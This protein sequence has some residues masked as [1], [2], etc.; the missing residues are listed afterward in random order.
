VTDGGLVGLVET[1]Q[2]VTGGPANLSPLDISADLTVVVD[3]H[4]LAVEAYT[5]RVFVEFPSL[6][7]VVDVLRAAPD[8]PETPEGAGENASLPALLAAADLTAV[9][10]VAGH[11]VATLG[12]ES[13]LLAYAGH[14]RVR[15][16]PKGLLLA[17][18]AD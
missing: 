15:L 5:D 12:G 9:A 10:S 4:E 16:H 13:G 3:G 6:G 17:A 8:A 14:E 7:A 1:I 18:L 2:R 11:D